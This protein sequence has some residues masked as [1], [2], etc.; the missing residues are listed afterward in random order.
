MC[1]V[2]FKVLMVVLL[3]DALIFGITMYILEI[4]MTYFSFKNDILILSKGL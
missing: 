2:H 4:T 1:L 3:R